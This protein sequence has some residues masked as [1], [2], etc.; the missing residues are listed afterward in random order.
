M[1]LSRSIAHACMDCF[2]MFNIVVPAAPLGSCSGIIS[3]IWPGF[4]FQGFCCKLF[5]YAEILC[6]QRK[7]LCWCLNLI[8]GRRA[9]TNKPTV[10]SAV[11]LSN[12]IYKCLF[13]SSHFGS[14]D[15]SLFNE[16]Q[17]TLQSFLLTKT[18][19]GETVSFSAVNFFYCSH[20]HSQVNI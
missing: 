13:A 4:Q 20:H 10:E 16:S 17:R 11:W 1:P 15:Q 7:K 6:R 14:E 9:V 19:K 8:L 12:K 5:S 3:L 2:E 18:R